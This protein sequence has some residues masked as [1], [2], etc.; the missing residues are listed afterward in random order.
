MNPNIWGRCQFWQ[1]NVPENGYPSGFPILKVSNLSEATGC[2]D[3]N[4]SRSRVFLVDIVDDSGKVI[5]SVEQTLYVRRARFPSP[6]KS[7]Q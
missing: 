1:L 3:N 5:A 4:V 6:G 7:E 2:A